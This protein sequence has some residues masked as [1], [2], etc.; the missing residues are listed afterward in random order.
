MMYSQLPQRRAGRVLL[1]QA[2]PLESVKHSYINYDI[3]SS[4]SLHRSQV[5]FAL[6]SLD[7]SG[8][9][10]REVPRS[11]PCLTPLLQTLKLARNQLQT[12]GQAADYPPLLQMLDVKNN[13]IVN[14]LMPSLTASTINCV[15]SEVSN[16][17]PICSHT[18]HENLNNLKF[19]YLSSNR[20]EKL[21]IEYDPLPIE[22][23][24]EDSVSA[25]AFLSQ[26]P[27]GPRRMLF[28]KLQGLQISHNQLT[29]LPE[30]IHRLEKLCELAFDNNPRIAR[31]PA[32]LHR[33]TGLFTLR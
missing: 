29:E 8:N 21:V 18:H 31:L 2:S 32:T 23:T 25:G 11:L 27:N 22:Q 26:G 17:S 1:H 24:L 13:G 4:S 5:G 20:L 3:D 15:Q 16:V 28:P 7:L 6:Q 19:L 33:L 12:L 14:P 9:D 30:T 10:L